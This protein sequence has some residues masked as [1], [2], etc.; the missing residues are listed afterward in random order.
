MR[1]LRAGCAIL[2]TIAALALAAPW[3]TPIDPTLPIDP[4]V[5]KLL[6]PGASLIV[7]GGEKQGFIAGEHAE[8]TGSSTWNLSRR[9]TVHSVQSADP[10][11]RLRFFLGTDRLGRDIAS[12]VLHGAR[13]TVLIA[14][15][16]AMLSLVFGTAV[17]AAAGLGPRWL[18]SFAMR[19]VDGLLA[20]P[21]F[22]L[23]LLLAVF[24]TPSLSSAVGILGCTAWMGLARMVRGEVRSLAQRDFILA[25][26]AAGIHPGRVFLRHMLPNLTSLLATE[27]SLRLSQLV[28]AEAALSFF[29]FG[30]Q[31]PAPSWG[32]MLAEGR[33]DLAVAWWSVVFPGIAITLTALGFHLLA[34]GLRDRLDPRGA[35]ASSGAAALVAA[36]R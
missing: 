24:L 17:G 20:F 31:P 16:A 2:A 27:T 6:P 36:A 3:L 22:L 13:T 29:G 19:W 9:G 12:R 5:A 33:G 14:V 15:A 25:A 18:D 7:F 35:G 32:S 21:G 34:D 23:A 1:S 26:R 4:A 10:P 8:R 11:R 28:L 30:V